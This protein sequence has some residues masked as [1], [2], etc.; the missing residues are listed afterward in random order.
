[1][2]AVL[3]HIDGEERMELW[4]WSLSPM[5]RAWSSKKW[6]YVKRPSF[7]E[8]ESPHFGMDEIQEWKH[9]PTWDQYC[10]GNR[11]QIHA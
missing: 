1:V 7:R 5:E 6:G 3:I 2:G 10:K 11:G 4:R 9:L 8:N